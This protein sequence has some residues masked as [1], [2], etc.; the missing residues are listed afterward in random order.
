[1]AEF[2]TQNLEKVLDS[3]ATESIY[4]VQLRL[5]SHTEYLAEKDIVVNNQ[6]Y[7]GVIET[8]DG[9]P[10]TQRIEA[11]LEATIRVKIVIANSEFRFQDIIDT[12]EIINRKVSIQKTETSIDDILEK[13]G[14]QIDLLTGVIDNYSW[15]DNS[16]QIDIVDVSR[17]VYIDLPKQTI[18]L[19]SWPNATDVGQPYPIIGGLVTKVPI[20]RVDSVAFKYLA[21]II[22]T[23]HTVRSDKGDGT[24]KVYFFDTQSGTPGSSSG[25]DWVEMDSSNYVV[26]KTTDANGIGVFI[27]NF[28][29]DMSGFTLSVD[30]EGIE[31][32]TPAVYTNTSGSLITNHADFTRLLFQNG[33]FMGLGNEEINI[34]VFRK[35]RRDLDTLFNNPPTISMWI[36]T[37]K[38]ASL[39]MQD[40]SIG[41]R[42]SMP[43]LTNK[44][45]LKRIDG[46]WQIGDGTFVIGGGRTVRL[47]IIPKTVSFDPFIFDFTDENIISNI[48]I[49]RRQI[50][51]L[52]N[53]ITVNGDFNHAQNV[54]RKSSNKP[55]TSSITK[56]KTTNS[57]VYNCLTISNQAELDELTED[58][59]DKEKDLPLI[60]EFESNLSAYIL[61]RNN[62][63]SITS[64]VGEGKSP[65]KIDATWALGDGTFTIG[66]DVFDGWNKKV[67]EIISLNKKQSSVSVR[68]KIL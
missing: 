24:F 32:Q 45:S 33:N 10:L 63:I 3:N 2:L 19:S 36:G 65:M 6:F 61:E 29:S 47:D 43:V 50:T 59:R 56:Y 15:D 35:A 31:D 42:R 14:R 58:L 67:A 5:D 28:T 55:S 25:G 1:M 38:N 8:I 53:D 11:G 13:Q 46:T 27:I 17:K 20:F 37:I 39:I 64:R 52:Q 68:A 40:I 49:S 26:E 9:I 66:L 34:P 21:C 51:E 41:M 12:Q 18:Q 30:I 44:I 48:K 16:F 62:I 23:G 60:A 57:Y 22:P 4:L 54:F 7:H